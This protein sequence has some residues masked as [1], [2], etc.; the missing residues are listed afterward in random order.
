MN[1]E[2]EIYYQIMEILDDIALGNI[3]L[4]MDV[5]FQ[6]QELASEAGITIADIADANNCGDCRN[7]NDLIECLK[8]QFASGDRVAITGADEIDLDSLSSYKSEIKSTIQSALDSGDPYT[9]WYVPIGEYDGNTWA[10]VFA[11]MDYDGEQKLYGKIAYQPKNSVMG[12]YDIDWV[13]PYNSET[14]EIWDTEI[15]I[16]PEET[17]DSYVEEFANGW[18]TIR[19]EYFAEIDEDDESDLY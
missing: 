9:T 2:V 11:F 19:S 5:I 17:I 13:I 1:P 6:L 3:A 12:E 4:T 10:V 15:E 18:D 16:D 7:W 14:G 8:A